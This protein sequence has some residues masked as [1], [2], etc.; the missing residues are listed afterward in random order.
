MS[1]T[2]TVPA[3][4]DR[5]RLRRLIGDT[6]SGAGNYIFEDGELDD[7]LTEEGSDLNLA[8]ASALRTLAVDR[9]KRA[10]YYQINMAISVS[11]TKQADFLIKLAEMFEQK[12]LGV[13]FEFTSVLD[14]STNLQGQDRSNYEDTVA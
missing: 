10:I 5:D 11:R 6:T 12:S 3:A 9:A 2:Y 4:S 8:A 7:I 1:F 13:P 14:Y